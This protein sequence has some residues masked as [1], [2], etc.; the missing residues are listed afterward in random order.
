MARRSD[1][2]A[3]RIAEMTERPVYEALTQEV[4][5][6]L[7]MAHYC[8]RR[9]A[10]ILHSRT[11]L[12]LRP[13]FLRS[14]QTVRWEPY[15]TI[16]VITPFN[17]PFSLAMMS[18]VYL[19]MAGNTIVIKPSE[20]MPEISDLIKELL[21]ETGLAPSIINV[22]DGG[23]AAA[24]FLAQSEM[25]SKVVFFGGRNG[26]NEL[27]RICSQ[28]GIP[29]VLEQGGGSSA[30]VL[31]DADLKRTAAGIAWS[32][33]YSG[34]HSCVGTDRVFVESPV[35]AR[36][37]QLLVEESQ[38]VWDE[39]IDTSMLEA[40][41]SEHILKAIDEGARYIATPE[42]ADTGRGKTPPGL[43]AGVTSRSSLLQEELFTPLIAICTVNSGEEAVQ[44][45]NDSC[46][47]LGASI[48]TRE[49]RRAH[50]LARDLRSS[51][52]WINDT[53]FGLPNLPWGGW[54]EAG[55]GSIFSR[56]SM[57][58]AARLKWISTN[59]AR[60]RRPWWHPYSEMKTRLA[61]LG[62]FYYRK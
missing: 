39:G 36:F 27:A 22:L 6:A 28:R 55:W 1:E 29:F 62:A 49:R 57:H 54:G 8:E 26:G 16:A 61:R 17:F 23:S 41:I 30:I 59:P 44:I 43:L 21:S 13:G 37:L 20:A 10:R 19:A 24:T 3:R 25:I 7:E 50:K 9:L 5:P 46:Q 15:G 60:G 32:G 48:W 14:R 47:M 4:F 45:A 51:V 2:L 33:F 12:Y 56:Y 35:E 31:A 11:S 52:I 42:G 53:S 40:P 58:E 34:G 38:K 18:A